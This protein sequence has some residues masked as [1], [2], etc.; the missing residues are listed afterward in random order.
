METQTL[1]EKIIDNARWAPSGD[2]MQT[3]RFEIINDQHF[4]VHGYDTR[5]HCVYDLQG[6]ASQLAIGALLESIVISAS[7]FQY[8]AEFKR[9]SDAPETKQTI[10][11][12][13]RYDST[14]VSD[15]LLPYLP[16]RSVQRRMLKTTPLTMEQKKALEQT[17][18]DLYSIKWVEGFANRCRTAWLMQKNGQLR[19][20]LP[21]AFH[22]HST[23]I[24]WSARFS[25]D[26]IPDQ[27][28]GLDPIAT[29]LMKWAMQSW[30]RVSFLN[31]YLSGTLLP[32]IE[33]DFLPGL[34][35]AGH[36]ILMA[37]E[38]PQTSQDYI[39]AGRALQRFWLEATHLNLQLQPEMTPLIFFGYVREQVVFTKQPKVAANAVKLSNRLIGLLGESE[40]ERAVFLGRIGQGKPA[41]ARSLRLSVEELFTAHS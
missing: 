1:I 13:L 34:F 19:L 17:V 4:V 20:T 12:F 35:C 40:T 25:D 31:T 18:G 15:P 9:R 29:K 16:I 32:R 6:H 26:K 3:W 7:A 30:A 28:V 21:E 23:I 27:A 36:F 10:D 5:E 14:V 22:T 37:K 38:K 24:E 2:N 39:T 33:L 41:Y 11:V 8:C